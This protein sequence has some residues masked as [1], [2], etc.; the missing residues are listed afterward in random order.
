MRDGRKRPL[1]RAALFLPWILILSGC[2]VTQTSPYRTFQLPA[3]S[4]EPTPVLVAVTPPESDS[5]YYA[6]ELPAILGAAALRGPEPTPALE[7]I[8]RA[9]AHFQEGRRLYRSGQMAEARL[10]FDRAIDV[11]LSAPVA[12][13]GRLDLERKL[14]ELSERI[15]RLDIEGLGGGEPEGQ[16]AYEPSPLDEIPELTFPIDPKLRD[17]V[18][19][20]LKTTVSQLPLEINDDVLRYV[21]Y[22]TKGRGRKTFLYGMSRAGRYR[23]MIRRIL[24]EEGVPQELIHLAQAESGFAPRAVSRKKAT[25]MWQFVA[26]RGQEYGLLR[27][28][29]RD[30]RLDPEKATR[31]AARHLKDLYHQF[32]DWYLA[33]AAYNCGPVNVERAVARSGYADVWELRRRGLLPKE[34]TAYVPIVLAM[35][36]V[37]ANPGQYGVELLEP[38]PSLEYSTIELSAPAHLALIGDIVETSL[39][40]MKEL[41]PSL[42]TTVVPAGVALHVPPGT[43]PKV[44]AALDLVPKERRTAWRLH[45]VAEEDTLASVA[46]FYK[47]TPEQI[48][49]ANPSG[50]Q[51]PEAGT[52]LVVPAAPA[53]VRRAVTPARTAQAKAPAAAAAKPSNAK[54]QPAKA[55][56]AKKTSPAKA[57]A[58]KQPAKKASDAGSGSASAKKPAAKATGSPV[59]ASL[60]GAGG[61]AATVAR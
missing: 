20:Q 44:L 30:D 21:D 56:P 13:A 8:R 38:A 22:F 15:Y 46:R 28:K 58:K 6:H 7:L 3:S 4:S 33:M 23:N 57:V 42:L 60:P 2:S 27:T 43:G 34:T 41:N 47:T 11:L 39:A 25:G 17:Q 26:W 12:G 1:H 40:G 10:Q 16:L 5:S 36:I 55:A 29:E 49:A 51:M 50:K 9:E 35:A 45:R 52:M 37:A 24:D 59:A 31:A 14:A 61:R 18:A 53:V 48:A 54:A 19:E 32:G